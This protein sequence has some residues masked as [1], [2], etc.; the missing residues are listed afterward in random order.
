MTGLL[1]KN[2]IFS[3]HR[4][5]GIAAV[6]AVIFLLAVVIFALGQTLTMSGSN[7]TDTKQQRDSVDALMLAESAVERASRLYASGTPCAGGAPPLG[8]VE[9]APN[10]FVPGSNTE[11]KII[12]ATPNLIGCLLRVQ[13][14]VGIVRRTADVT[15]R[16]DVIAFDAA[17]SATGNSSPLTWPHT[18]TAAGANRILLVGVS[19]RN[20]AAQTVTTVTYADAA[21]TALPAAVNGTEAYAQIWYRLNPATGSNSS[22]V[23]TLSADADAEVVAGS[24]SFT[25]VNNQGNPIDAS[26]STTGTGNTATVS[27]TTVANNAWVLDTLARQG[28]NPDPAPVMTGQTVRWN[29]GTGDIRGAG[30]TRGPM[31]PPAPVT[32]SWNWGPPR[33]WSLTAVA[34]RP[35]VSV[36][37]W[38][39]VAAP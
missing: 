25:G 32:M 33:L 28:R 29:A 31:T 26:N 2:V 7:I 14:S 10:P 11:F 30:S 17:T 23:V 38:Q 24:V 27:L 19:L 35:A 37:Q 22:V 3:L 5:R 20:N 13:G 1:P 12:S 18:V 6:L 21:L 34:L 4:Q 16:I 15:L 9:T 36:A 39:E 8:L